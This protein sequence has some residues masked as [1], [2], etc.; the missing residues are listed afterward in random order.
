MVHKGDIKIVAKMLKN[1][2]DRVGIVKFNAPLVVLPH[3]IIDELK[4]DGDWDI[5]KYLDLNL[6]MKNLK[7]LPG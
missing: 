3:N 1:L 5:L 7:I 4:E 6:M 2:E